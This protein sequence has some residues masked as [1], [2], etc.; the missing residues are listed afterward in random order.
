MYNASVKDW[1][2]THVYPEEVCVLCDPSLAACR[3]GE[4]VWVR[5]AV[6][7]PVWPPDHDSLT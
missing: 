7:P 6:P 1:T 3:A 2:E 5:S 4:H